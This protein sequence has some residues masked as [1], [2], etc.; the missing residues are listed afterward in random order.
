[1]DPRQRVTR[2]LLSPHSVLCFHQANKQYCIPFRALY[3]LVGRAIKTF[4]GGLRSSLR[5][6]KASFQ[7]P[8]NKL[9]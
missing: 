4:H 2:W 5:G 3:L 8:I 9:E 1:M 7:E 6:S